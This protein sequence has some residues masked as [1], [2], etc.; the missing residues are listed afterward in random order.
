MTG[1]NYKTQWMMAAILSCGLMMTSCVD[2]KTIPDNPAPTPGQASTKDT[3][4][5]WLDESYMDKNVKPGDNF[6]MYCIGTWWKNTPINPKKGF[7]TRFD[8]IT[9]SFKD[10]VS[11]LTDANYSRF[12]NHLKWAEDGSEAAISA[13]KLYDDA[14]K[15]SGLDDAKTPEDV[16]RAFGKMSTMGVSSMLYLEPFCHNDKI[17]L[18]VKH[19]TDVFTDD[20]SDKTKESAKQIS[21]RQMIQE[22]PEL[23]SHLVPV[24]GKS[25]TRTIPNSWSFIQY[26]LEG[27]GIDPTM[28]YVFDD[29]L[30]FS[31]PDEK[32]DATDTN[33]ALETWQKTYE[34]KSDAVTVLKEMIK[35]QHY[36]IDYGF[37]SKK[38]MEEYNNK[39]NENDDTS[40]DN[41]AN[42]ARTRA[43]KDDDLVGELK[44]SLAQLEKTMNDTYM[45]YLRSKMVADQLMPKGLKED[46]MKYCKELKAVFAQ[47]I[48][49]N[50]WLSDASKKKA[51]EKLDAMVFNVGYPDKWF[52]EGLADFSK[53]QSLLE[54]IYTIRKARL[55]LVKTLL[56]KSR[57]EAAFTITIMDKKSYL[58]SENAFYDPNCN[59]M[60][61]MPYY[62][63]P[64]FFDP[65]QSLAINYQCFD[66]TGH[67]MTH[68]FD[69][70]G[71]Q[72]D[73]YGDYA[74]NGLLASDADKAEF[75]RRTQLLVKQYASYDVLPDE[76]P[77][78]KAQGETTLAENIAD[79]GGAEIAYQTFLNRLKA[80]GY[81]D[82]ELKLMKQRFF[83]AYAEEF[84]SKYGTEHV[85]YVAFGIERPG[86]PDMHSMDKERVNGVVANMDGWY[87]AF[88]IKE[89]ALYRKP[90]DRIRIW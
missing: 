47:R 1:T 41:L 15:L 38:T 21:F 66:T 62:M 58:G 9:P 55:N 71:S 18:L 3:G 90:A 8:A 75:E 40:L 39:D 56:G 35:S 36:K 57:Q 17:C 72:F 26:I 76:M 52:N 84:R 13:K 60:N 77:G 34:D 23:L 86:G 16:L 65:T 78:K 49:D 74:P 5:W 51:L 63:L 46:Y 64:P 88:D 80:D 54:D 42:L 11:S 70:K 37:I 22:Q 25:G 89:G 68:G 44:L 4:K 31:H 73:K 24:S 27:M 53:S 61:I 33:G 79:L 28:V 2:D 87:D 7:T 59:S 14:L 85:N 67:E 45:P 6:Y 69:T 81:T 83:L 29:Y 50:A 48:K 32:T 12:K 30:K 82:A 43:D 20:G 10:R 19:N